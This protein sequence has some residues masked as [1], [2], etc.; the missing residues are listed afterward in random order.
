MWSLACLVFEMLTNNFLFKPDKHSNKY[1]AD[2][3]HLA[4]IIETLGKIPK[5]I[6]LN[7]KDSKVFYYFFI[8]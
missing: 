7:G 8:S 1:S 3:D 6:A 5:N 4:L 2:D